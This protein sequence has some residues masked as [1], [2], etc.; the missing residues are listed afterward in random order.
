MSTK[1][2]DGPK[3]HRQPDVGFCPGAKLPEHEH[4]RADSEDTVS[5]RQVQSLLLVWEVGGLSISD[6]Q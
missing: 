5:G 3:G 6:P 1:F 4:P 2:P